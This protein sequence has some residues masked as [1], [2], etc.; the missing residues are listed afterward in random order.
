M[1]KFIAFFVFIYKWFISLF[2]RKEKK[3]TLLEKF[4]EAHKDVQQRFSHPVTPPHN[5]RKR[6]RGRHIQ[7]MPVGEGQFRAIYHGPSYHKNPNL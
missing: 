7:Y 1:K 4:E 5:N 2:K 6:T 3:T